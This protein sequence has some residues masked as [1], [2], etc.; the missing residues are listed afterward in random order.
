MRFLWQN[1]EAYFDNLER[2]FKR[3]LQPFRYVE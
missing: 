1:R 3:H 2:H